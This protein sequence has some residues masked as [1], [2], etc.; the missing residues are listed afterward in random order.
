[1]IVEKTTSALIK[2][3]QLGYP[4]IKSIE[5]RFCQELRRNVGLDFVWRVYNTLL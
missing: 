2:Q 5:K 4:A 1:M 3:K